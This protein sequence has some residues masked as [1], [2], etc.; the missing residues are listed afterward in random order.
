MSLNV[1]NVFQSC[2]SSNDSPFVSP[3]R[4]YTHL[5]QYHVPC[6]TLQ[7]L[8]QL[9]FSPPCRNKGIHSSKLVSSW[10]L[11]EGL[12]WAPEK[13][14]SDELYIYIYICMCVYIYIYMH[15]HT[16]IYIHTVIS[17]H[18][19]SYH[20]ISSGFPCFAY[21]STVHWTA[22]L[23]PGGFCLQRCPA[24]RCC[25]SCRCGSGAQQCCTGLSFS[26]HWGPE[27]RLLFVK[28]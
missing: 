27:L 18:I 14:D 2:W 16:Y 13:P 7:P 10:R 21:V 15:T 24:W 1:V 28:V 8:I 17:C 22:D 25:A 11:A 23:Q 5:W 4:S 6:P 9:I 26:Q 12:C 20:V 3:L 19:M